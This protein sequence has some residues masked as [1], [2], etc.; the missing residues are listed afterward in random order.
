MLECGE[1]V[2]GHIDCRVPASQISIR[3]QYDHGHCQGKIPYKTL[4]HKKS[5]LSILG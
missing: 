1:E 5:N 2:L 3:L 4:L